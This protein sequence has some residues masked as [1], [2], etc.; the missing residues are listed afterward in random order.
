MYVSARE[1]ISDAK[2]LRPGPLSRV[3]WVSFNRTDCDGA[4]A[5][6]TSTMRTAGW[7]DCSGPQRPA[8]TLKH[9]NGTV[10]VTVEMTGSLGE[11]TRPLQPTDLRWIAFLKCERIATWQRRP[12]VMQLSQ[13]TVDSVTHAPHIH[14]LSLGPADK[15]WLLRAHE[16]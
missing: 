7:V 9:S 10:G 5:Q 15:G 16:E 11:E 13:H 3:M 1:V 8:G 4:R 6:V 12:H 14:V 2:T